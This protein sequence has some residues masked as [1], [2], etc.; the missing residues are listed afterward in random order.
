R[1]KGSVIS[2]M[3][4]YANYYN[5]HASLMARQIGPFERRVCKGNF[6]SSS[7]DQRP[8]DRHLLALTDGVGGH[9]G[10]N[11]ACT[12]A[13]VGGLH[14]PAC[15]VIEGFPF[16][17]ASIEDHAKI[18]FLFVCLPLGAEVR[19]V[20]ANVGFSALV[21]EVDLRLIEWRTK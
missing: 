14:K 4:R 21:L 17:G 16:R 19:R 6:V 7:K 8:K 15:D 1:G 3:A 2:C 9:K 10:S 12:G 5:R 18:S 11:G 13:V 20:P